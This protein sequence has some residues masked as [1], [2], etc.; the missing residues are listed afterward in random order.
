M[1]IAPKN[2]K[3][4]QKALL[5]W[6]Q[7]N[8]RKLPW[9]ETKI[10]YRIWVSEV[11][12]QQTQ[13]KTVVSYYHNFIRQFPTIKKLAE[14]DLQAVLK[15]WEGLGYYARARN[16]HKAANI[17]IKEHHGKVPKAYEDIR[18]L[19]SIGDYVAAAVLSIA[20]KKPYAVVDGNVKRVLARLFCVN[21][22]VNTSSSHKLFQE[23]ATTLLEESKPDIFNQAMMEIGALVCKPETPECALCPLTKYCCAFIKA[24]T[25]DYPKRVKRAKTPTY[26]TAVGVIFKKDKMLIAQRKPDGLLG[27]LWEFPGGKVKRKEAVESACLR[28]VKEETNITAKIVKPITKVKHA[29]T[30][31]KIVMD[32]FCC[33]YQ[34]GRVKLNG[35]V[36]HRWIRMNEIEKYPF[37]KANHKFFAAPKKMLFR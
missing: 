25:R 21:E 34:S 35:P 30:H 8:L 9:R 10:P 6:Y 19:P 16:L 36:A 33:E 26:H 7:K 11:M 32:V 15:A 5:N 24:V 27:G 1:S 37:P 13:V 2:I 20:Y 3:Y 4:L 18:T 31:F 17:V 14:A 23:M 28:E 29:Y 12:L 22:T